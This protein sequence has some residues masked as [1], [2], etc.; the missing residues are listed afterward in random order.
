MLT[1]NVLYFPYIRVPDSTWFTRILLYWDQIHTITPYDFVRNPERLDNHTRRLIQEG[2]VIQIIPGYHINDI[3]RFVSSFMEWLDSLGPD[4]IER[5][6]NAFQ[7]TGDGFKIHLEKVDHLT[8]SLES[9]GLALMGSYPWLKVEPETAQ[10]FM[11]YLAASLGRLDQLNSAP[12]TDDGQYLRHFVSKSGAMTRLDDLRIVV[13]DELFPA[14]SRFL[15]PA[16]IANFKARYGAQL[17]QFRRRVEQQLIDITDV[18]DDEL[19]T[20]RLELFLDEVRGDV[21]AI[22]ERMAS[23]GWVTTLTKLSA[24]VAAIPGVSPLLGLANAVYSAFAG[25]EMTKV[26]SPFLYAAEAQRLLTP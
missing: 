15:E 18:S 9:L 19:R 6:R 17:T 8:N 25:S 10:E 26:T 22:R 21:A 3:P 14:P 2:L 16:E 1:T 12:V 24:I 13:L 7:S 20:R 5:R 11:T 23:H 4:V